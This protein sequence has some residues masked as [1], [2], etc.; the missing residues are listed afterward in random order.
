MP[1]I[2]PMK[3]IK[4]GSNAQS[5]IAQAC[6]RCRSKKIRCDGIRPCCTQCANVGFECKTSDKLSR[7]AF[8]RGYTESLEER[9]RA[10]ECEVRELKDL[11][12]EKD[13]KIDMLSRIHSQSPHQIHLPPPR[14]PSATS[15]ECGSKQ[16][17]N[18]D[19][20]EVFKVQQS[21]HLLAGDG[22]ESY[23]SGTSSSRIFIDAF[24]QKAQES[25][26]PSGSV[27]T[28][29][30]LKCRLD[31]MSSDTPLTPKSP[32]V[33]KA[34]PR[35]ISDQLINKYFQEWAPLFPVL[36]R[37]LFL[38][39]YERYVDDSDNITDRSEIAQ[40]NLVFGIAGLSTA[41]P[42]SADL[43]SF[44]VQWKAALDSV[45]TDN[46]MSTLQCLVLAQIYCM[47]K[48]DLARLLTY[49]GLSTTLSARLGLHQSQ[50][51]FAL[52]TLTCETRKK[53][54]WTLYTV[55]SF[56]SVVLGLPKHIRDDDVECEYPVDAD[57]EY[58]T[59]RGFQPTLPGE[60]TK[61]SSALALF[62]VARIL[63]NVLEDVF[64]AKTTYELSLNNLSELSDKL[65]AWRNSLPQHLRLQ[66]AQDKPSTG[67]ISS[68]SPILSFVYH[69]IRALIHRP[70]ICSSTL[71]ARSHSSMLAMASSSKHT[72]QLIQLLDERSMSFS[73][74][75]NRDE[76]LVLAGVGLLFQRIKLDPNSK[77]LKDN[78]KMIGDVVK[79]LEQS[80]AP[81]AGAFRNAASSFIS[82][83]ATRQ[84]TTPAPQASTRPKL[85]ISWHTSDVSVPARQSQGLHSSTR[86]QF[87]AI[88]S[89]FAPN[90]PTKP[91]RSTGVHTTDGRRSASQIVS[92]QSTS[93]ASQSQPCLTL[94]DNYNPASF[95]RSEPAHS[96]INVHALPDKQRSVSTSAD[97]ASRSSIPLP[98][99]LSCAVTQ[100]DQKRKKPTN[101]DYLS[102]GNDMA[103]ASNPLPQPSKPETLP[104][105]WEKLL[106]SLDNGSTNIFDACYGGR[107]VEAL[108]DVPLVH[109]LT[110]HQA[111]SLSSATA[112]NTDDSWG[113]NNLWGMCS[114][115]GSNTLST[116][117]KLPALVANGGSFSH[118]ERGGSLS[119]TSWDDNQDDY[120]NVDWFNAT[121]RDGSRNE[122]KGIVIPADD[123]IDFGEAWET[124]LKFA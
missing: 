39:L 103:V 51:R 93:P 22:V 81:S 73:F 6:D 3:V 31:I 124:A 34:P 1:G 15:I 25:G 14:R 114:T 83:S 54:F 20:D 65:D 37:P 45:L 111:S 30:L 35:L 79:I 21:P 116:D 109:P 69:Y 82:S 4:V 28:E 23:F 50:K 70:A 40:L 85:P 118:T 90:D 117:G 49:K 112:S 88:T 113:T 107:P 99:S 92:H 53:V 76:V 46:C 98:S 5:R 48:G 59:D 89:R 86:K 18:P 27:D 94:S 123:E 57:D 87:K 8:P 32:I 72:I 120:T 33:W 91:R 97:R 26:R 84:T 44:E 106:S 10:L 60:F 101:L 115:N 43:E 68:R 52:D 29:K 104:T 16:D 13:E 42:S 96:P 75:L 110:H 58:V 77:I 56:S 11:L 12:D 108:M 41:T 47:Q 36:H 38:K 95:S 63:S 100:Q 80:Q 102:F 7:R 24:K 67:T 9:V 19:R 66:F 105:D 71:G 17:E 61:L 62:R 78:E 55:D 121:S 64:P 2:L 122:F 119:S 74:C